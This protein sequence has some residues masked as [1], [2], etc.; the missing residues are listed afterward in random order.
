M[1]TATGALHAGRIGAACAAAHA[2]AAGVPRWARVAAYAIPLSVLPSSLWRIAVCTFRAPL[3][4][5]DL[6]QGLASSGLPGVPLALYVVLLSIVSELFAFT[7][8]GLVSAWGE[9]SR[10]GFPCCAGGGCRHS[11][12][13]SPP[14]WGRPR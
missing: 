10:S 3:V 8:V 7:A 2:P 5:G 4:R 14:R 13:S 9:V 6:N 1:A 12:R 11:A